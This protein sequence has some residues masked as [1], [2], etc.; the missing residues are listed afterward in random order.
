MTD[1]FEW[2]IECLLD[3]PEG[4]KP[5]DYRDN[6]Y[7]YTSQLQYSCQHSASPTLGGWGRENKDNEVVDQQSGEVKST[8]HHYTINTKWQC[9]R[10]SYT[11]LL[12]LPPLLLLYYYYNYDYDYEDDNQDLSHYYS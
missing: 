10:Y 6:Y 1:G 9:W 7:C 8:S 12:L 11:N 5:K 4:Q 3:L 2:Y